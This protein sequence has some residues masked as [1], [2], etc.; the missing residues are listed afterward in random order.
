M[1]I[2]EAKNYNNPH[3]DKFEPYAPESL[4]ISL[5]NGKPKL[6]WQHHSP[7][8]D[9]WVGYKVYRC[10]TVNN[11]LPSNFIEIATVGKNIT[12]Y[13]DNNLCFANWKNIYYKVKTKNTNRDSEFSNEVQINLT[14]EILNCDLTFDSDLTVPIGKKLTIKSGSKL[15]FNSGSRLIVNGTLNVNGTSSSKVTFDFQSIS[16]PNGIWLQQG[17][18]ANINYSIIKNVYYGIRAYKT[19]PAINNNDIYNC[20]YGIFLDDLNNVG[21]AQ[22]FDNHIHNGDTYASGI[23][24]YNSRGKVRRN[25]INNIHT[26]IYLTNNSSLYLGEAGS[27]GNNNIHNNDIG[28]LAY[29]NS[30]LFLGRNTCTLQGGD[31]IVISSYDK[32]AIALSNGSIVQAEVT[33]WGSNSESYVTSKFD[34]GSGCHIYYD[35]WLSSTPSSKLLNNSNSPEEALFNA[36]FASTSASLGTINGSNKKYDYN[37]KWTIYWKLLY[38]RNL[39]S[40]KDYKFAREICK[41]VIDENPDSSLSFWSLNLLGQASYEDDPEGFR[42]YLQKKTST[43]ERKLLYGSMELILSSYET[44]K[45]SK[46]QSIESTAQR[47]AGTSIEEAALFQKFMYYFNDEENYDMAK[48]TSDELDKKFPKSESALE[49]HRMLE[50]SSE[51]LKMSSQSSFTKETVDNKSSDVPKKYSLLG[52]YP[53]PFNP[54]TTI[55]YALPYNSDVSITIYNIAGQIVKDFIYNAQASGYHN[56]YWNGRNTE[57]EKV[58]SGIYIYRFKAVS[59]ENNGKV[60]EKSS[61][62]MLLK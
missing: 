57:G 6:N 17:S 21:D 4:T 13:T 53:N 28:M 46:V 39:I 15:I 37:P 49:A 26:G 38:A 20:K 7:A 36:T 19:A 33:W 50:G 61:K 62:L 27:Y 12:S 40:V 34:I 60:F 32:N 2:W 42:D 24:S 22:I 47:Y 1:E 14:E 30:Y 54:S 52:N 43:K 11:E 31:N 59:L 35:P 16:Y 25:E 55:S 29:N 8:D 23:F 45:S 48:E 10:I 44:G 51:S 9:Y 18:S 5:N 3:T 58:S 41:E 56:V